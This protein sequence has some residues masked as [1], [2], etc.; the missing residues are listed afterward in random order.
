MIWPSPPANENLRG[1]AVDV[2]KV[3]D[4][5]YT[6]S[7]RGSARTRYRKR[8]RMNKLPDDEKLW[9]E[10]RQY[11]DAF[12]VSDINKSLQAGV[13]V[14]V[15]VLTTVGIECLSGYYAGE[16]SKRRHFVKF[17]QDFMPAYGGYADDI[18]GCIRNG[19]AHD[20][21]IKVN[22]VEKKGFVF[23]RDAGEPHLVATPQNPNI[24]YLNREQFAKDFLDAQHKFFEMVESDQSAWDKAIRRLK[25]QKGFLTV[26]SENELVDHLTQAFSSHDRS[27]GK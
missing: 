3:R 5:A 25:S 18:Y 16:E 6:E 9:S 22:L 17:M 15:I 1:L 4:A 21:V 7:V 14:G 13:E 19:L 8:I 12:V 10:F 11:F 27:A 20:Y 24:I 2:T 26:R 23:K